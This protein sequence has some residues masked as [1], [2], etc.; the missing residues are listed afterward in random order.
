MGK[1]VITNTGW[2]DV[3]EIMTE[4]AGVLVTE[5]SDDG[6]QQAIRRMSNSKFDAQYI[7]KQAVALFSLQNGVE[8]YDAIYH[9]LMFDR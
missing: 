4:S 6:Y 1:P 9:Q 2:G 8:K 5:L 3:E 7:R